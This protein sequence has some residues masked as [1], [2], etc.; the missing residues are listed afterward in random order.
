MDTRGV[1]VKHRVSHWGLASRDSSLPGS[2]FHGRHT[3]WGFPWW[4][5]VLLRYW[6]CYQA[7]A[8][9][10]RK[11]LPAETLVTLQEVFIR[12]CPLTGHVQFFLPGWIPTVNEI[13]SVSSEACEH[14]KSH[15]EKEA[16]INCEPH[17]LWNYALPL[18]FLVTTCFVIC[19][20]SLWKQK[21]ILYLTN[22]D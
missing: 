22:S 5:L 4:A 6:R 21:T 14:R 1:S 2:I 19:V 15:K 8:A 13:S 11:M 16:L 10:S 3:V 18:I 17:K 7:S 12:L 9:C 20:L